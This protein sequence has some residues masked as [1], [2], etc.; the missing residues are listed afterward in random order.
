M[1]DAEKALTIAKAQAASLLNSTDPLFVL[2]AQ[3]NWGAPVLVCNIFSRPSYWLVPIRIEDYV[4]G[5]VRVSGFGLIMA[6][7]T[8]CRDPR[9]L[10][11][12]PKVVTG[13]RA[14]EAQQ[15]LIDSIDLELGEE[16]GNPLFVHDGPEGREVWMVTTTLNNKPNR[17]IF[18]T[19]GGTYQRP[20]GTVLK[21]DI[22][23]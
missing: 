10:V 13:I 14:E 2:W 12:C 5:F 15:K 8:F 19:G 23:T 3:G 22:E 11:T 6:V 17:W 9:K 20:A 18:I 1:I 21:N 16:T 4:V 7:G